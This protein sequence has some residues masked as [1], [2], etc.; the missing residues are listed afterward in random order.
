MELDLNVHVLCMYANLQ[1]FFH[2]YRSE[3]EPVYE[4]PPEKYAAEDIVRILLNS[5]IDKQSVNSA[6][7]TSREVVLLW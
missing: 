5:K 7:W 2:A 1:Y 4:I 3:D 6:P